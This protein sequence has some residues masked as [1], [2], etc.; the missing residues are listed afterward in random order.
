VV[1]NPNGTVPGEWFPERGTTP[2][3]FN[4]KRILQ[5]FERHRDKLIVLDGVNNTV[6][7]DAQNRG[8]PHQRGIGSLFTGAYLGEGAF[9]DGCGKMAGW[10][11][12]PSID[13]II[14]AGQIGKTPL[15]SLELGVRAISHDVQGRISYAGPDAP[16]PPSNDPTLVYER[17]F[18]RVAPLNPENPDERQQSILDT[19]RKQFKDVSAQASSRDKATLEAHLELVENYE[20]SLSLIGNQSARCMPAAPDNINATAES[21]MPLVSRA[22]LE[23]LALSFSCDLTRVASLAYSSGFNRIR[24]PW[25]DDGGEG[26]TLSH[27]G[28][29]NDE[30]WEILTKRATWHAEEL[31]WFMDRLASMPEGNG[32]VLDN[33]CILWG[34]EVSKGNSHALDRIPLLIAGGAGARL[35]LGQALDLRGRSHTDVLSTLLY[36]FGIPEYS[37]GEDGHRGQL[38]EELLV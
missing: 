19:V 30:A 22:Q 11:Q 28:D 32:T 36:A 23:L 9:Q 20:Y 8:G 15:A 17:V 16:L 29:S 24:Y 12:K 18:N 5:P 10:A 38:I 2:A 13:Q 31:A 6:A 35:R 27:S 26:H 14:A 3:D 25:I 33:T 21:N 37:L 34:N 4:L 7:Q 1:Y